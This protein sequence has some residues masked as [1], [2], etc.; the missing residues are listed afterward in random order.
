MGDTASTS[1]A[2][3]GVQSAELIESLAQRIESL[4]LTM[5]VVLMLEAHKPLSFLGSQ[6]LLILQ[7]LLNVLFDPAT[8][9]AYAAL[10]EDRRSVE[11]L[12]QRLEGLKH[13][14]TGS[15]A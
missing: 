6:V 15:P 1:A 13:D 5:P 2:S 3:E 9:S 10:L 7:P 11:Q 4:G 14:H 12:I 8:S